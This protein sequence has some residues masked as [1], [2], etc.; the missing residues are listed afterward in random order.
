LASGSGFYF[1][2][3]ATTLVAWMT[4]SILARMEFF[5]NGSSRRRKRITIRAKDRIGLIGDIGSITGRLGVN[6]Q[7]IELKEDQDVDSPEP[8]VIIQLEL[9]LPQEVKQEELVDQFSQ[10]SGVVSVL[11]L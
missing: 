5:H 3:V 11:S 8:H 6:I 2:A 1:G 7:R 4:L 9:E 10:V